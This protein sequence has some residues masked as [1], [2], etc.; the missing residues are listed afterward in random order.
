M[1]AS[2]PWLSIIVPLHN[3]RPHVAALLRRVEPYAW[4]EIE[5]IL[6]D[7]GSTDGTVDL[8][9]EFVS[10]RRGAK[11][12][13]IPEKRGVANARNRGLEAAAAQYIWF[14]DDDDVWESDIIERFSEAVDASQADVVICRA[15]LRHSPDRPGVIIDGIDAERIVSGDDAWG[16]LLDG[17]LNGYLWNKLIR[18]EV[19]GEAPFDLLSSQS[20]FTGVARVIARSAT[21]QFV[22]D[23][24]YHHLI[25][26]G[27]ITR[28]KDPD[29]RNLDTAH[30]LARDLHAR[31]LG[32]DA[33]A[34]EFGYFTAWFLVV[35]NGRTP[36][37]VGASW[38]IRM[39][40]LKRA[41]VATDGVD[42]RELR[43]RSMRTYRTVWL[44]TRI[45]VPYLVLL[46]LGHVGRRWIRKVGSR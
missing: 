34:P 36:T 23:V 24:L 17:K 39:D 35:P 28:R 3:S 37:R 26:A 44:I 21:V 46:H 18:R 7:D 1:T 12:I 15:D 19:L 9:A 2:L 22:P 11:L 25:R 31:V 27:S 33:S 5:I 6:V 30:A 10:S 32:R 20:D 14:A 42:L 45:G 43:S 16:L 40:G 38:S 4:P 41:R 8:L 13:S 29:L